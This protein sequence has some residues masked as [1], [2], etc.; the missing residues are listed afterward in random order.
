MKKAF[1]VI[2][3]TLLSLTACN[4][5]SGNQADS[6]IGGWMLEISGWVRDV[7]F[8]SDETMTYT[9]VKGSWSIENNRLL[10]RIPRTAANDGFFN[11]AYSFNVSG[12]G[13][14]INLESATGAVGKLTKQEKATAETSQDAPQALEQASSD[15]EHNNISQEA[16]NSPENTEPV[17]LISD[18][19]EYTVAAGDNLMKISRLFDVS[20]ENIMMAS[21]LSSTDNLQV[22]RVLKIPVNGLSTEAIRR[23]VRDYV[24]QFGGNYSRQDIPDPLLSDYINILRGKGFVYETVISAAQVVMGV[25]AGS[26][27]IMEQQG[28]KQITHTAIDNME[29]QVGFKDTANGV[30][31]MIAFNGTDATSPRDW[32]ANTNRPLVDGVH[33]GYLEM[34][35]KLINDGNNIK[36]HAS[37][38]TTYTLAELI[39]SPNTRFFLVGH[40]M[41]GAIAQAYAI[42]LMDKGVSSERIQGYT[43]NSALVITENQKYYPLDM[44][45]FNI[46]NRTDNVCAGA[47]W[48]SLGLDGRR[49]GYD[50]PLNDPARPNRHY[51]LNSLL[52]NGE[53]GIHY[54]YNILSHEANE[55][56]L[57]GRDY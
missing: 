36:F 7:E 1:A 55:R 53:H 13:N 56:V 8:F 29:Y 46:M 22:G 26:L 52:P 18:Y 19:L 6:F 27:F 57:L 28:Y 15:I 4:G 49:L 32:T 40:S 30:E 41:G 24:P 44:C 42:H 16:Q 3:I 12:D 5:N 43:F 34:A 23:M 11:G 20:V 14:T 9:G 25:S 45:W 17:F 31:V 10:V 48:F 39:G 33:R 51:A 50:I 21:N 54:L 38:I 47:V 2:L 37:A 35:E